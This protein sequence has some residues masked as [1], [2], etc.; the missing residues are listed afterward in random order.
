[1]DKTPSLTRALVGL[2]LL[3]A[4]IAG[5][6]LALKSASDN[7][8]EQSR[9]GG[10]DVL[11]VRSG[12]VAGERVRLSLQEDGTVRWARAGSDGA[13]NAREDVVRN[14]DP[15]F[16]ALDAAGWPDQEEIYPPTPGCADCYQYDI[17]FRG[18]HVRVFDPAPQQYAQVTRLLGRLADRL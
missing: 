18:T 5:G 2:T 14:V 1:M 3:I 12:G 15:I 8:N 6:Y 7:E 13:T 4:A 16:N 17:T 11:F 9:A 10:G